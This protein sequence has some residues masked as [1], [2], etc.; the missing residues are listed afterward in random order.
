MGAY[1]KQTGKH[2]KHSQGLSSSHPT[3]TAQAEARHGG[4]WAINVCAELLDPGGV[5]Q[6]SW[7]PSLQSEPVDGSASVV[8]VYM[9]ACIYRVCSLFQASYIVISLLFSSFFSCSKARSR[10]QRVYAGGGD[11]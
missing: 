8:R 7:V 1:T 9:D 3:Q 6:R 5:S 11:A 10:M 2:R 4:F